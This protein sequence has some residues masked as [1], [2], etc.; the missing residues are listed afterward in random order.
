MLRSNTYG[1]IGILRKINGKIS[2]RSTMAKILR[3]RRR[4]YSNQVVVHVIHDMEVDE[5]IDCDYR[6][7]VTRTF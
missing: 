4:R 7:G 6:S 2:N 3:S 1:L 5:L